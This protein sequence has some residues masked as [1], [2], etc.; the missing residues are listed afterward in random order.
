MVALTQTCAAP[1]TPPPL[2]QRILAIAE[3][4]PR[5]AVPLA[6]QALETCQADP[7]TS[8]WATYTLGW[9]LLCWERSDEARP[10]LQR[11]AERFAAEQHE[12]GTLRCDY[13]LLFADRLQPTRRDLEPAFDQ[14]A[15]RFAQAGLALDAARTR[16]EQARYLVILRRPHDAATILEQIAPVLAQ[17]EPL[18]AARLRCVQGSVANARSDYGR[19]DELLTQAEQAFAQLHNRRERARCW[20]EQAWLALRREELDRALT[21]YECAQQA[22]ARLDLPLLHAFCTRDLGYLMNMRGFYD[23]ALRYTLDALRIFQRCA[24]P[25]DQGGCQLHLGNIY[26]Y[27]GRWD[28]ALACYARAEDM[29]RAAGAAGL[30]LIAQ[31][32]RAM[33]YRRQGARAEAEALLNV[34]ETQAQAL[35]NQAELAEIWNIQAALLA[36]A[37]HADAAQQRYQQAHDLFVALRNVPGAA[38]CLLEQ[39]WLTLKRGA[40]AIAEARFRQ[41]EPALAQHPHHHWRVEYGLARCA[42]ARGDVAAALRAYGLATATLSGLRQQLVSEEISSSLYTQAAQLHIDALRL[43]A[44]SGAVETLIEISEHQRALVLL[45]LLARHLAPL[46]AEYQAEHDLLRQRIVALLPNSAARRP[47]HGTAIDATLAAYGELLLRARHSPLSMLDPVSGPTTAVFRLAAVRTQLVA[48]YGTDWT[49]LVYTINGA[50]LLIGILTPQDLE[51]HQTPYD[52]SLQRLLRQA[53][54]PEYRHHTY[55][56]VAALQG[57]P[58][59][60]WDRL[61]SLA[62]RLLPPTVRSRLHAAHRLLIV[63]AGP[64][65]T[66]PW[67]ALRLAEGWLAEQAIIQIV[68]SLSAWQTLT[69]RP[70]THAGAALLIGCSAFAARATALPTVVAE[71]RGVAQHWPGRCD[72]L[73]DAQATHAALLARSASGDLETYGL[74]HIASHAQLLSTWGLA[75]HIKLWESDVL[76]PEVAGLRLGGGLVTLSA[77]EGAATDALPG[78][79]VLS[80]SWAFLAAGA[81]AVLASMWPVY[82]AAA[83]RFMSSFYEE[84]ARYGDAA[85]A[86]SLAQRSAI[87][88]YAATGDPLVEPL[89]WSN[90]VLIG[91]HLSL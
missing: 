62:E 33:V 7:G 12:Y 51:L 45:R 23:Q 14:L 56:D 9:A 65:N 83:L 50:V 13:A 63:P 66:L 89:C 67:P 53:S 72:Q 5:R 58:K 49:T 15:E 16:L 76:L 17:G 4:D 43:A 34:V 71:L 59:R 77:C 79:E 25:F 70:A 44:S 3:R 69:A 32:N 61:C 18:D 35:G 1:D 85:L 74:V 40:F 30:G 60:P 20:V 21:L 11:A 41:A 2:C 88:A 91:G 28:A 24:R 90:F 37:D 6:R 84:L 87:A 46:P 27:T 29:Y 86:L 52:S 68:P 47:E 75:A 48:A 78:E 10:L 19:A 82:D 36:D 26:F 38:E 80:L 39:G 54:L 73:L 22:F 42:E 57:P 81:R 55:R 31:R 8:V 64:L